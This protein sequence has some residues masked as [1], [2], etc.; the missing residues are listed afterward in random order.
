MNYAELITTLSKRLQL[1]KA[2]VEKRMDD[3]TAIITGELAKNNIVSIVNFGTLEAK[4]R[5]ERVSVHPNTGK[6]LLVPPKM[7]V[8]Y[9]ASTSLNKKLKELKP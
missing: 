1:T 7:V 8:K 5:M 4:K 9:K 3:T 6:K 2:D